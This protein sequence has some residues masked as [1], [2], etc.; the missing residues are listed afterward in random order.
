MR[1]LHHEC[2]QG[3]WL[4]SE[5]SP[6]APD[7]MQ[8]AIEDIPATVFKGDFPQNWHSQTTVVTVSKQE[9]HSIYCNSRSLSISIH[10]AH[11]DIMLPFVTM[12]PSWCKV[13]PGPSESMVTVHFIRLCL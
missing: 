5:H 13:Q 11:V 7:S 10:I 2:I 9:I 8:T 1:L 3:Q 4:E 6:P 12:L